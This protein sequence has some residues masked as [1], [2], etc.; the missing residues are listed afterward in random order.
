MFYSLVLSLGPGPV[1]YS[2]TPTT[3]D[4]P[5]RRRRPFVNQKSPETQPAEPGSGLL[6]RGSRMMALMGVRPEGVSESL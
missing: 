3:L 4:L 5:L 1:A 6:V 2:A